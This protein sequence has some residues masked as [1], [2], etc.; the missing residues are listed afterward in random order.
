M[1]KRLIPSIAS[2]ASLPD[3][4]CLDL[5]RVSSVEITSEEKD[6]GIE[7]ALVSGETRGWRA[8]TPGTQTIRL[9]FDE[10][11]RL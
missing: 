7:Y 11:Q 3:E 9:I 4:G 2:I 5:D 10:P 6:Y 1:R 8:A